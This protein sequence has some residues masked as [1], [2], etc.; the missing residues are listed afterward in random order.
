MRKDAKSKRR[1]R[2]VYWYAAEGAVTER[3]YMGFINSLLRNSLATVQPMPVRKNDP[4]NLLK[5]VKAHEKDRGK[6]DH[7]CLIFDRDAWPEDQLKLIAKWVADNPARH[8]AAMTK[9]CFELWLLLHFEEVSGRTLEQCKRR[10]AELGVYDSPKSKAPDMSRFSKGMVLEAI[11]RA[12]RLGDSGFC[13]A[14][15]IAKLLEEILACREEK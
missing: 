13:C 2:T 5:S 11:R 6:G 1:A 15:D 9:P 8:H 3:H 12:N 4:K 10:L 7:L 14:L